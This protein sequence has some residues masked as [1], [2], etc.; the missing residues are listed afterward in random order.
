[1]SEEPR[2]LAVAARAVIYCASGT[3]SRAYRS[4]K[5]AR[6][7]DVHTFGNKQANSSA[8]MVNST[9]TSYCS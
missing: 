6:G 9:T 2:E 5:S 7:K 3:G 4:Y 1:M 8:Y